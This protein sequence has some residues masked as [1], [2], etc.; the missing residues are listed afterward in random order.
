MKSLLGV[1]LRPIVRI[2]LRMHRRYDHI[3]MFEIPRSKEASCIGKS[4]P[5]VG[6]LLLPANPRPHFADGVSPKFSTLKRSDSAPAQSIRFTVQCQTS[7]TEGRWADA[8]GAFF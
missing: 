8:S 2:L 1:L 4:A 3:S 7:K 6:A 5:A